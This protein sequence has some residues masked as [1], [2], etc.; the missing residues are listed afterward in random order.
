MH[1]VAECDKYS[2]QYLHSAF[3]FVSMELENFQSWQNKYESGQADV[4]PSLNKFPTETSNG[5]KITEKLKK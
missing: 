2:N 1:S 4:E 3:L 5:T